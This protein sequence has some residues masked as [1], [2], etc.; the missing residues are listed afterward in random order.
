MLIHS[1]A[2]QISPE[3]PAVQKMLSSTWS[4]KRK[5]RLPRAGQREAY[6]VRV[7]SRRKT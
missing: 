1:Y 5:I 3:T 2:V 4:W 6:L 7:P